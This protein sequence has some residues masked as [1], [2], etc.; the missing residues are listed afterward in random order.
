MWLVVLPLLRFGLPHLPRTASPIYNAAMAAA[1]AK[2]AADPAP[3]APPAPADTT[4]KPT[5]AT[6]T[7]NDKPRDDAPVRRESRRLRERSAVPI[8][9]ALPAHLPRAESPQNKRN[10]RPGRGTLTPFLDG[11]L[12]VVDQRQG[13][14]RLPCRPY[15]SPQLPHNHALGLLPDSAS[16]SQAPPVGTASVPT[17]RPSVSSALVPAP[18]ST[19]LL[20][21][22]P[23]GYSHSRKGSISRPPQSLR[24]AMSLHFGLYECD[25]RQHLLKQVPV[26]PARACLL[27]AR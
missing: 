5:T 7:P 4:G 21:S 16:F 13:R 22:V 26:S 1:P 17:A 10:G 20:A 14:R 23:E 18:R 2:S 6:A 15:S 8:L 19:S 11:T 24:I 27:Y 3:G 25:L 9:V 12:P